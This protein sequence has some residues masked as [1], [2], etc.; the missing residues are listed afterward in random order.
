M[1][2][3]CKDCGNKSSTKF[4][5]GKCPACNSYNIRNTN[6]TR[7]AIREKEP[8]T[9]VEIVIMFLV[10]GLLIYGVWDKFI[11]PETVKTPAK[12]VQTIRSPSEDL[13]Y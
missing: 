12:A 3:I 1:A 4:P 2:F 11:K 8:K 9:L 5:G 13:G 7:E 6:S 10:W